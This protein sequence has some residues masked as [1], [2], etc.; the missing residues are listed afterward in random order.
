MN[1][2]NEMI[3]FFKECAEYESKP[4]SVIC[5]EITIQ[6]F[7][8]YENTLYE[9]FSDYVQELEKA[10]KDAK[11]VKMLTENDYIILPQ[12]YEDNYFYHAIDDMLKELE[13]DDFCEALFLIGFEQIEIT[14]STKIL[15]V[16]TENALDFIEKCYEI[17]QECDI[18]QPEPCEKNMYFTC[19]YCTI[20]VKYPE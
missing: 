1:N 16:K 17:S 9:I 4:V 19:K 10:K 6:E 20:I 3:A 2:H 12:Y 14:K 5:S 15:L 11:T 18:M 13:V 7:S 8:C